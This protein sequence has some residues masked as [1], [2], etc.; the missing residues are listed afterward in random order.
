VA[1]YDIASRRRTDFSHE[2]S[3]KS[4]ALSPDGGSIAF[5]AQESL[6]TPTRARIY[7][8]DADGRNARTI[9]TT[10]KREEL[11]GELTWSADGRFVY[12]VPRLGNGALFR[13]DVTGGPPVLVG[14]LKTPQFISSI[15][16]TGDGRRLV[17][18][19]TGDFTIEI[20][21]LEN[22]LP[23]KTTSASR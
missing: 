18:G 21:A 23:N 8:A 15:E 14:H 17:Y 22:L 13:V 7:V 1:A 9:F 12:F 3:A 10:E 5:H 6:R 20:W 16:M 4:I 11:P 2:G 19:A